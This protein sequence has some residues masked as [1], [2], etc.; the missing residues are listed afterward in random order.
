MDGRLIEV[1][2]KLTAY[3]K[4]SVSISTDIRSPALEDG[5]R[6]LYERFRRA[7]VDGLPL[8]YLFEYFR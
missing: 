7:R 8:G 1:C 3:I 2:D 5:K 4:A 6:R